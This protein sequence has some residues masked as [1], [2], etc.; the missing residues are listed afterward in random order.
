M[1]DDVATTVLAH[2]GWRRAVVGL[3]LGG[4]LGLLVRWVTGP[5]EGTG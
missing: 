2:D 4:A 3:A 5:T 1:N